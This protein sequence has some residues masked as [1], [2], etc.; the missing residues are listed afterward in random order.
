MTNQEQYEK[1]IIPTELYT[2]DHN[3]MLLNA[4]KTIKEHCLKKQTC[5]DCQF[6]DAI[7]GCIVDSI[8]QEWKV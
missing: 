6:Y 8:P 1:M 4:V 2:V 7:E 3:K 5:F